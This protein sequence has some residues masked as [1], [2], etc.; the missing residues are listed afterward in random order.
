MNKFT[1]IFLL[2]FT[3]SYP[4]YKSFEEKIAYYRK[5]RSLFPAIII[6]AAIFIVWDIWFTSIG[7]WRFNPDYVIGL[8]LV[9]LPIEEWLFFII[10]PFSCVFIYEVLNYFIQKDILG[11]YSGLITFTLCAFLLII[12]GVNHDKLYT[13]VS[14][15]A[16]AV[17]LLIQ[18]FVF[19]SDY[20]GRYYISW[21][22]CT[23]PFFI[24]NGVLTAMPVLIYNDLENLN[25][26]IYTIPIED[27]FYGMLQFLM[28][29]TIYEYLKN[30]K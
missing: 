21:L 2:V 22:V 3:L 11:K 7:I 26:R 5:W 1:Y 15:Y 9:N 18:Q 12:G 16:L 8:Y 23:I 28:V 19:R 25:F 20:M 13:F 24:V 4:L 17:F 14:F 29:I 6:S 30:R 27:L 10:V